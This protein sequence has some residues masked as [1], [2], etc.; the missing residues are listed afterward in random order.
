MKNYTIYFEFYG[1][2]MKTT[3]MAENEEKAKELVKS[4]IIFDKVEKSKDKFNQAIDMMDDMLNFIG[5][6][7]RP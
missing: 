4:K 7:K 5:R 3:I 2:K 1:K 6:K